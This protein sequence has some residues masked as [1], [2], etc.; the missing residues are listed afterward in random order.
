MGTNYGC[1]QIWTLLSVLSL[2]QIIFLMTRQCNVFGLWTQT[3]FDGVKESDCKDPLL[4]IR[5]I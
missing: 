5:L 1:W 4:L 3:Q 2:H